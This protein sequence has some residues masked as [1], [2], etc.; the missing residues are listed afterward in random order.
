MISLESTKEDIAKFFI[1]QF[2]FSEEFG[3]NIINEDV[4]GDILL[5]L[6]DNDLKRLGLK[7]GPLKKFRKFLYDNQKYFKEKINKKL[8][9]INSK[10]EE[11]K[12]FFENYLKFNKNIDD[13]DGKKLIEFNEEKMKEIGLNLGQRK[14]LI[15]YIDYPKEINN[16]NNQEEEKIIQKKDIINTK[17]E[18]FE[19]STKI[20]N[21]KNDLLKKS[22][23]NYKIFPLYDQ[24]KYNIFFIL[25]IQEKYINDLNLSIYYYK[26]RYFL[27]SFIS[28]NFLLIN[29]I[30]SYTNKN[31][32]I[33]SFILQVP[34][35]KPI[36]ELYITLTIS[37][38][39]NKKEYNSLIDIKSK[40]ENYF[41][42]NK[43]YYDKNFSEINE[44]SIF[45]LFISYFFNKNMYIEQIFKK[46]LIESFIDNLY[47][48]KKKIQLK[49]ENIL[50]FI[51][52]CSVFHLEPRNIQAIELEL[53]RNKKVTPLNKEYYLSIE[54]IDKLNLK[55]KEKFILIEL[56]LWIYFNYDK[57]YL[58]ILIKLY[59]KDY[60]I[61]FI[62]YFIMKK[63]LKI[64]DLH[65]KNVEE[66]KLFKQKLLFI[67]K[68]ITE[69]NYIIKL[70]KGL[71]NS[72]EFIQENI[73]HINKIFEENEFDKN[74][75]L[76]LNNL[77]DEDNDIDKIYKLLKNIFEIIKKINK[78]KLINLEEIFKDMVD[79]YSN[80]DLNTFSHLH[81]IAG[82]L[83]EQKINSEFIEKFYDIFH[84]KG[85][86]VI[87]QKKLNAEEIINFIISKDIY[88]YSP[89]FNKSEK[90]DPLIFRYIP[91]TDIDKN[92]LKNIKLLKDYKIYDLYS[93][94]SYKI[95]SE[96]L[97]I[98]LEQI[99]KVRDFKSIFDIFPIK[100]ID[101]NFTFLINGKMNNLKYTILDEE[102]EKYTILFEI[103][104][105]FFICNDYNDLDLGYLC[106]VI[107]EFLSFSSKYYFH[108]IMNKNMEK[109]FSKIKKYII[110][111]FRKID[112]NY[113]PEM[114]ICKLLLSDNIRD[115][116]KEMDNK[117]ITEKDFYQKEENENF[118]FFKLLFENEDKIINNKDIYQSKYLFQTLLIKSKIINDLKDKKVKFNII[119]NL[120]DEGDSFYQKILVISE[121]VKKAIEIYSELKTSYSICKEKIN[122]LKLINDY[123]NTFFSNSKG[124]IIKLLNQKINE[125]GQKDINDIIGLDIKITN[126]G[127]NL[128]E[129]IIESKNLKYKNSLFFMAIYNKKYDNEKSKNSE[130]LILKES[131]N[132]YTDTIKRIITHKESNEPLI[133]INNINEIIKIITNSNNNMEE[134]IN[135][136]KEEFSN[137]EK[138]DY[139]ENHL[140]ND[141]INFSHKCD[142]LLLL[143]GIINFIEIF[144]KIK[145]FEKTKLLNDLK[146]KYDILISNEILKEEIK[147]SIID[148]LKKYDYDENNEKNI[149]QFYKL[150]LGKNET[151]LFIK[152]LKDSNIDINNLNN[153]IIRSKNT[154][155]N[156][157]DIDN[158]K[159]VFNF[160]DNLIMNQE[161]KTDEDL[162]NIFNQKFNK[163]ENIFLEVNE[164]LKNYI[165]LNKLYQLY[166]ENENLEKTK[167][168]FQVEFNYNGQII[169]VQCNIKE[170]MK[171]IFYKFASKALIDIKSLYFLYAGN[172]I[173]DAFSL[174]QILISDDK[175]RNKINI[176]ANPINTLVMNENKNKSIIKSNEVICPKCLEPIKI[177]IINYK[178]SLFDCRNKH[179][180]D[181]LSFDNFEN[182]QKINLAEIVCNNCKQKN[183]GETFNNEFFKCNTCKK[184]LCPLCKSSHD[185]SHY[186]INYEQKNSLCESHNE[187]YYSYCKLCKNNLCMLCEKDHINHE[188]IYYGKIMPDKN[189]IK[190][191]MNELRQNLNK[192]N[193]YIK[194][195]I[196]KLNIV[197]KNMEKYYQIY[198][199][200]LINME[201][202]NRNYEIL[203]NIIEFNNNDIIKDLNQIIKEENKNKVDDILNLYNKMADKENTEEKDE[204]TI[205]Y[206]INN[207]EN[208]IRIFGKD[209]VHNNKNNCKIVYE[210]MEYDLQEFLSIN[211][212]Q[213]KDKIEIKLKGINNIKNIS[214]IFYECSCLLSLPDIEK[215]DISKVTERNNMFYGCNELLNIPNKFK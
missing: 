74:N 80:K 120:M 36:Q 14:K 18:N 2:K 127:F 169:N 109:I 91:I 207:N 142:I 159:Y 156:K 90:R 215:W 122:K 102:E 124:Q 88:Y 129:A 93:E 46:N 130:D 112:N 197:M 194:D 148:F 47:Y 56:I 192:F 13:L 155:L 53:D 191:K 89:I 78:Y 125:I 63:N 83:K 33:R 55:E 118:L 100:C 211:N 133:N 27:Q 71:T 179:C 104:D 111:F 39:D 11:V 49:A 180:I 153:Y 76:S 21:N 28:Y 212:M 137:L 144:H 157:K 164:Y 214:N 98:I 181:N 170:K 123:Y 178:I 31:T 26:D 16:N 132:I 51:K 186:I 43:L 158:L 7:I 146:E 201:K 213:K 150:L 113:T 44:D 72:L 75:Y 73:Y 163:D 30:K 177:K 175:Q 87:K 147:K 58:M 82:L 25:T 114:L 115:I 195:V 168:S 196:K 22:F 60:Y 37:N 3:K 62:F 6:E 189:D 107:G 12:L 57:E 188:I 141:L 200:I 86:N 79:Y 97:T 1:T 135:F 128:D 101:R 203:H 173:N 103:L 151:I 34:S 77:T 193:D 38:N 187:S 210:D 32:P 94:S 20:V 205:I 204:I 48:S 81:N 138:G 15:K 134:E 182:T 110:L 116:L 95:K 171:N 154:F 61:R 50:I 176:L 172:T 24:T 35:E 131:I 145:E 23:K 92:Y 143:K 160:F 8:I 4:S 208:L 9:T 52:Y 126:D 10:P 184:N 140:L 41:Y 185:K 199:D 106:N 59:E 136:I 161:I 209:F 198:N 29:E 64:D 69:I 166:I 167:E 19:P 99:K 70:S 40:T 119:N 152:Q 105:N 84:Q 54:E 5:D 202:R 65:F 139:I 165:E 190:N 174:E 66:I 85:I 162:L 42:F 121:N 149:F 183:K 206:K 117:I 108:L 45:N 68:S 17:I 67:S 96:F